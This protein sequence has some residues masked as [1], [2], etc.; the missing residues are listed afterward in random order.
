MVGPSPRAGRV[1]VFGGFI[2]PLLILNSSK[3]E[4]QQKT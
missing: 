4:G 2:A 3:P 1:K